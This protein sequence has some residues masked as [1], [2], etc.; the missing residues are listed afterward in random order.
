MQDLVDIVI[1]WEDILLICGVTLFILG[2]VMFFFPT[3]FI[4]WNAWGNFWVGSR[5]P[6]PLKR[7]MIFDYPLFTHH[8]IVGGV[9]WGFSSLFLLIYT[10]Y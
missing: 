10:F 3:I 8:K 5:L 1:F 2:T 7:L 4:H 6:K 9:L